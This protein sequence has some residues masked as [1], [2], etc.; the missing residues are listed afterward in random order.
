MERNES[1]FC[2]SGKKYNKCHYGINEK[3][4]LADMYKANVLFDKACTAM[5]VSN[6]CITGCSEC[7]KDYFF[8]SENE[9]LLILEWLLNKGENINLYK[10]KAIVSLNIIKKRYPDMVEQLDKHMPKSGSDILTSKYFNDNERVT[11]LPPCIFLNT[12]RKCSI[13]ECRPIVC[14]TYGS[15]TRCDKINNDTIEFKETTDLYK[16]ST[17]VLSNDGAP[18]IKRPYPIF[19]W[20]S[21]FL[22]EPFYSTML[23]KVSKIKDISESDYYDFS[24]SIR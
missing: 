16:T 9:F 10:E 12:E 15:T 3:S 11:D 8:V 1:C 18:I 4:K 5:T 20:F 24:L 21:F 6:N 13:Y 23:L 17:M 22:K 7:C 14:R 19:Y 2:G